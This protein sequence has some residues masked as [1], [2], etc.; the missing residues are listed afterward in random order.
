MKF[1]LNFTELHIVLCTS[2]STFKS[3]QQGEMFANAFVC[4]VGTHI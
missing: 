4:N 2:V 3:V 1:H